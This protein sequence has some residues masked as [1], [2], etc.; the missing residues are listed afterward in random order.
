M[1]AKYN[2]LHDLEHLVALA[3][4]CLKGVDRAELKRPHRRQAIAALKS[5]CLIGD[6][7]LRIHPESCFYSDSGQ[8]VW[9]P[10]GL[11]ALTRVLMEAAV[12]VHYFSDTGVSEHEL[13]F[14][15]MIAAL[16]YLRER[17]D[18]ARTLQAGRPP[19]PPVP[20]DWSN[21]DPGDHPR[22]LAQMKREGIPNQLAFWQEQLKQNRFFQGL[23]QRDQDKWLCG[24]GLFKE[25]RYRG[26]EQ[27]AG[28]ASRLDQRAGRA[29]VSGAKYRALRRHFSAH[30]HSAPHALDQVVWFQPFD[31]IAVDT[32]I[33][34]PIM[35]CAA[36]VGLAI[37]CFVKAFPNCSA[38]LD[39]QRRSLLATGRAYLW[40]LNDSSS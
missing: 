36:H 19:E 22:L 31:P 5:V 40:L 27:D 32:Q 34:L 20:D 3:F 35:V 14:R 39:S 13:E 25:E 37:E 8:K 23:P 4:E 17:Q 16:H 33:N 6:A 29:G 2:P 30:I 9:N 18:T 21:V 1:S 26:G 7:V 11:A 24:K 15:A 28:F 12:N 38:S 10:T